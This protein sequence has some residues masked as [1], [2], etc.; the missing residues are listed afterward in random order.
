MSDKKGTLILLS[1]KA[2]SGKDTA[3]EVL[4]DVIDGHTEILAFAKP[5]KDAARL[6]YDLSDEQLYGDLKETK[7]EDMYQDNTVRLSRNARTDEES[8]T[9]F[10]IFINPSYKR[11]VDAGLFEIVDLRDE[12]VTFRKYAS[13]RT[14]LQD[15]GEAARDIYIETWVRKAW[16]HA[17]SLLE[18]GHNA[19]ITDCRHG[20]EAELLR[21]ARAMGHKAIGLYMKRDQAQSVASHISEKHEWLPDYEDVF[22]E[23]D[24]NGVGEEGLKDLKVR[25]EEVL[26]NA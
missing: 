10:A 15:L 3:G 6:I 18:Q 23:M 22:V 2:R 26:G 8:L 19:V 13:P 14:I 11:F 7:I 21:K 9:A 17:V 25:L 16:N 5:L 20:N 24:N 1:G 12:R 4:V